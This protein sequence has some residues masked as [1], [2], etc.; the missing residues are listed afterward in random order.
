MFVLKKI[1]FL[2]TSKSITFRNFQHR[3]GISIRWLKN[4][5]TLKLL[6]FL[7]SNDLKQRKMLKKG[8]ALLISISNN[9]IFR[10]NKSHVFFVFF[11]NISNYKINL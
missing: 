1:A 3:V 11:L 9:L 5:Q 10:I 4:M 8:F 7:L 6:L 2:K